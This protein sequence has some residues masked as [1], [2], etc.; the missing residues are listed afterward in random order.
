MRS[1][2][3]QLRY[4]WQRCLLLKMDIVTVPDRF[5][6]CVSVVNV[7]I[8]RFR[9][10]NLAN[11]KWILKWEIIS[12]RFCFNSN[13]ESTRSGENVFLFIS[14]ILFWFIFC[15]ND[16]WMKEIRFSLFFANQW[17]VVINNKLIFLLWL[18]P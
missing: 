18:L 7:K 9:Y 14:Y 11:Y 16:L 10:D 1:K 12:E 15:D 5:F 17:V 3:T 4:C 6:L 13:L 2:K 8:L